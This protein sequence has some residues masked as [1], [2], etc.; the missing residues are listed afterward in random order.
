MEQIKEFIKRETVF[1]IA[2]ILTILSMFFVPPSRSYL[3]YINYS[4]LAILF[5]LM[6]VV[7]GFQKIGVFRAL[8]S[9]ILLKTKNGKTIGII[10][11]LVCFFTAMLVTNDVVLI[12]FVPF[13][14]SILG[15][16]D[17][18]LIFI[19]V[20]ETIAAN[21]GSMMTP[22][23]NPQNLFLYS[24]YGLN[25]LGF[26][27]IMAPLGIISF[28]LIIA[29]MICT[30]KSDLYV[31]ADQECISV[32]KVQ[33]LKY[34]MMFVICL[35]T[36]LHII[37]YIVC[38]VIISIV[39]IVSDRNLFRKIDYMLLLTFTCFF[40]FV[41]NMSSLE[42]I[43][44]FV[45][46]ILMNREI[47]VSAIISQGISNVPAAIMLAPFTDKAAKLLIGVNIGGLGTII[48]SM[49]SLISYKYYAIRKN[50]RKG[51]Y[52]V[53]FSLLNFA[54]LIMLLS[55]MSLFDF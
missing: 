55:G 16:D 43:R 40:I 21:L 23:G 54:L 14:I 46:G 32:N 37:N 29:I 9:E 28:V 3:G 13:T 53:V 22:I 25:I 52:L 49:A 18:N 30:R 39:L 34:I 8:S 10:F 6:A 51:K 31:N 11:V 47:L 42:R 4:V 38:F 19:I 5:C 44:I 45:S 2:A 24:Y 33:L 15:E 12:T 50:A 27:K 41:G 26:L 17:D 1:V 48:A 35:L 7:A 36:V 20:M